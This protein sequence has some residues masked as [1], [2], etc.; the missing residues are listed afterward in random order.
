MTSIGYR[1]VFAA[2]LLFTANATALAADTAPVVL[3][4]P[5]R[6]IQPQ[7]VVDA[8]GVLHMIYYKGKDTEG[9][10][11]YVRRDPDAARFSEAIRVNSQRNSAIA[12]GTIRG[13]QIAVGKD[14][15]V[16]VAWNGSIEAL[17][18]GPNQGS[19]MLYSRLDASGK[20]FEEQR[21]LMQQSFLLDGPMA[22][23]LSRCV[24]ERR[25]VY[26]SAS[27]ASRGRCSVIARP[28]TRVAMGWNSPRISTG[29]SGLRS[30]MSRC[31][32]PP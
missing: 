9:D 12:I 32:G 6:G 16:H 14:G 31:D 23:S 28:G 5:D 20:A 8:Q 17:P 13:G 22:W 2:V 26:L 18:K 27:A 30:R 4:T 29:A 11:Y 3:R 15:R 25:I 21:N 1:I 19:P 7:A 10:L 24:T